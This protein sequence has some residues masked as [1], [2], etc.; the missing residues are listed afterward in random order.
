MSLKITLKYTIT[1]PTHP[2]YNPE[3]DGQAGIK[4]GCLGCWAVSDAY[5]SFLRLKENL[6]KAERQLP[7]QSS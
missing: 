2:K 7:K 3:K 4:A 5:Y 1:C 6:E